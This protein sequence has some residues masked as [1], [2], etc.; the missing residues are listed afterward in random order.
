MSKI[1]YAA[2]EAACK[3]IQAESAVLR[4]RFRERLRSKGLS[5]RTI[6]RHDNNVRV[7]TDDYLLYEDA[8]KAAQG[9]SITNLA[10]FF[11]FWF[12]KKCMW[13]TPTSM[14]S[15]AA[16]L[17]KFYA[18]MEE[19]GEITPKALKDLNSNIKYSLPDWLETLRRF[20]DPDEEAWCFSV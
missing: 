15:I 19:S 5:Q 2:L 4:R 9:A 18:F 3:K 10:G 12:I 8:I 20:D 6:D 7:Y 17:K 1:D 11:D 13:A 16:S 14:R